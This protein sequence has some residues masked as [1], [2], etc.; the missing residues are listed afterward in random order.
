[1][2][3]QTGGKRCLEPSQVSVIIAKHRV[4][5]YSSAMYIELR[6]N[7]NNNDIHNKDGHNRD[8]DNEENNI[9][10]NNNKV[11]DN[12]DNNNKDSVNED[13]HNMMM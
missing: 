12:E 13:N 9:V 3:S 11:N 7:N 1:M 4:T 8:S 6:G 2:K 5:L 10:N